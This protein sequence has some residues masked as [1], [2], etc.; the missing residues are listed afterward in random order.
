MDRTLY[1]GNEAKK[2]KP[3]RRPRHLTSS[4]A[5]QYI[6]I[7]SVWSVRREQLLNI[8]PETFLTK[9]KQLNR[10][11]QQVIKNNQEDAYTVIH[12]IYE[13]AV[14]DIYAYPIAALLFEALGQGEDG[15]N[16]EQ[17]FAALQSELQKS[18][19][20]LNSKVIRMEEL[21]GVH[22]GIIFL[23]YLLLKLENLRA[24]S[25][26]F[27]KDLLTKL[28]DTFFP[29]ALGAGQVLKNSI[30][31][32][33]ISAICLLFQVAYEEKSSAKERQKIE[34]G[35]DFLRWCFMNK[36]IKVL[37]RLQILYTLECVNCQR[38]DAKFKYK[39][40][41][42]EQYGINC[43]KEQCLLDSVSSIFCNLK[44]KPPTLSK[45]KEDLHS[46]DESDVFVDPSRKTIH[47]NSDS[48][49]SSSF[50]N[51]GYTPDDTNHRKFSDASSQNGS[52]FRSEKELATSQSSWEQS[53]YS[54]HQTQAKKNLVEQFS[55]STD[56]SNFEDR[57]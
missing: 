3:L 40:Y 31:D 41:Y 46:S 55:L 15:I 2:V 39:T 11:L 37:G 25:G 6:D 36:N 42:Q 28:F 51:L 52:K 16:C 23:L 50:D 53:V 5:T 43:K 24:D 29:Y 38:T 49:D 57:G 33:V 19:S 17:V 45:S 32:C 44:E 10:E 7:P 12:L 8:T 48:F 47:S 4:N 21:S 1:A 14:K 22:V 20:A 26:T 30:N 54:Q 13:R 27:F 18:L 56:Q 35:L 9:G 34:Q